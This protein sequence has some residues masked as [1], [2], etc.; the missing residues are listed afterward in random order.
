MPF[1][2]LLL[3]KGLLAEQ[4]F[5]RNTEAVSEPPACVIAQKIFLESG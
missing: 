2:R 5:A 3:L 1:R 4:L